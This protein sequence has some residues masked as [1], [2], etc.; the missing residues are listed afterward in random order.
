MAKDDSMASAIE[1]C[2]KVSDDGKLVT[3]D[4][5]NNIDFSKPKK[6]AEALTEV[7]F[8]KD[9][10]RWFKVSD[11]NVDFSPDFKV[12]IVLAEEHSKQLKDTVDD[13]MKDLQ[14]DG[15]SRSF[16]SEINDEADHS[17]KISNVMAAGAMKAAL[18]KHGEEKILKNYIRDD[19]FVDI[20]E[21]LEIRT[22]NN[23]DLI[24]WKKL[25]L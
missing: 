24:N 25:P 23:E 6:V 22:L 5:T 1:S 11:E 14:K 18:Y 21:C 16:S 13:F 19:L 7:F 8:R 12:R 15:L 17:Q 4:L 10:S 9:A 20:L 2:R 3:Y